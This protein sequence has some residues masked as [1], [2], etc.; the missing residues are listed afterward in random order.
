MRS[1]LTLSA[2]LHAIVLALLIL[3]VPLFVSDET[4]PSPPVIQVEMAQVADK[5]NPPPPKAAPEVVHVKPKPQP[6]KPVE[7]PVET[8]PAPA[9]PPPPPPKPEIKP[10]PPKPAPPP[11]PPK[12]AQEAPKPAPLPPPTPEQKPKEVAKEAPPAPPPPRP[13]IRPQTPPQKQAF[14]PSKIAALLNKTLKS[15]AAPQPTAPDARPSKE[16][17]TDQQS[18]LSQPLTISEIDAVRQQIERNW[19]VPAGA[20]DAAD[21]VVHI[22]IALNPDGTLEGPPQILDQARLN[23][24]GQDTFRAAAESAVRA[25]YR[26]APLKLPPDKYE[27]WKSIEMTFNPK[28]MLGG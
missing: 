23:A 21:L 15:S 3:G 11:P 13:L 5:T 6:P 17:P 8:P 18:D 12:L 14:D 28:D 2:I 27:S 20:R 24:A 10:P 25:I 9:P 4:P 7:K 19:S 26:S 22:R 16:P 1:G